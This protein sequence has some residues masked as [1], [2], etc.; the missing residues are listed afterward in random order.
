MYVMPTPCVSYLFTVFGI[1]RYNQ[2]PCV[3]LQAYT[4]AAFTG[5]DFVDIIKDC[6]GEDS[7]TC[8][9][10]TAEA[11]ESSGPDVCTAELFINRFIDI[12]IYLKCLTV[13]YGPMIAN[14][15]IKALDDFFEVYITPVLA[16]M[17][18]NEIP[19]GFVYN[20]VSPYASDRKYCGHGS[21]Y[22]NG[23]LVEQAPCNDGTIITKFMYGFDVIYYRPMDFEGVLLEDKDIPSIIDSIFDEQDFLSFL[24][25]MYPD[26][27]FTQDLTM[28]TVID[29]DECEATF[30]PTENI[31]P[32]PTEFPSKSPAFPEIVITSSPTIAPST[33]TPTL[34]PTIT[35]PPTKV[36]EPTASPTFTSSPSGVPTP[37]PSSQV[38]T[39]NP[40]GGGTEAGEIPSN[41]ISLFCHSTCRYLTR[42]VTPQWIPEA[43]RKTLM[44][45]TSNTPRPT[46]PNCIIHP[47]DLEPDKC[48]I[49]TTGTCGGGVRG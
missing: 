28:C 19:E 36:Y 46:C 11:V 16:E 8:F 39:F 17:I 4:T 37:I 33:Q 43:T 25:A 2:I 26:E 44:P 49:V 22:A 24:L 5:T 42:I 12:P 30:P 41:L 31:A 7:S 38:P 40:I 15:M 21:Y 14:K 6:G 32:Q 29:P 18:A 9:F 48:P 23:Y 35:N 27:D 47:D 13:G 3:F 10:T 45:T 34:F 1:T 20:F